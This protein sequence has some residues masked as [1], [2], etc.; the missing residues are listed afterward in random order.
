VVEAA[1]RPPPE[2]RNEGI[3]R[4]CVDLEGQPGQRIR[5]AF[6]AGAPPDAAECT[7]GLRPLGEWL[8]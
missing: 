5:I 8:A 2:N 4:L 7:P 1:T 3:S 6:A